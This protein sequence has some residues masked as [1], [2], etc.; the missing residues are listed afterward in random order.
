MSNPL[1]G[2]RGFTLIEL[3]MAITVGLVLLAA[4]M[5]AIVSGQRSSTGIE[6]KVTTNQDARA[7]LELMAA[8][9]RMASFNATFEP[10]L[11][12]DPA[13]CNTSGSQNRRGI[14]EATATSITVE[15]DIES[16]NPS[17]TC[18]DTD[19]EIIRY[20]YDAA[21][22]RVTRENIRCPGGQNAANE[23]PF[24]GP[25]TGQPGVRTVEVVNNALPVFR[26][27]DG[28]GAE[29]LHANLPNDIPRIRRIEIALLVRSA[30][31][32]PTTNQRRQMAYS[33]SIIPRNHGIQ[34]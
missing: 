10:N 34:F 11:W 19:G 7:A 21:N 27:F 18:G 22:S 23:M 3:V 2:A 9:I 31:V 15:M 30:D 26:Y 16:P 8:E 20:A 32:D 6:R 1:K 5:T 25:I 12:R 13:N 33:T 24:L 4:V 14:Q 28:T 29:I 17:R